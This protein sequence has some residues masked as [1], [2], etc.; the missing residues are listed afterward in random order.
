MTTSITQADIDALEAALVSGQLQVR[1]G[2]RWITY[3]SVEEI[4]RALNYSR[5]QLAAATATGTSG[6]TRT[7]GVVVNID[8]GLG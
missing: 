3:R 2:D 1:I 7:T 8:R 5:K 4:E 6:V